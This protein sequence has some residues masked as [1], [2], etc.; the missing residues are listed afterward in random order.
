MSTQLQIVLFI[1]LAIGGVVFEGIFSLLYNKH[2][3]NKYKKHFKFARYL[4]L[5]LFPM[6]GTLVSFFIAGF[7]AI[8]IFILFSFMGPA[9][10][11][12]IGYSYQAI[13]G[14]KLWTY[15]RYSITGNTSLLAIPF[16]GLAGLLFYYIARMI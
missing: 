1:L 12:C 7:S 13:V 14:Q 9:L 15:H 10:E 8:K 16:W 5:L 11:W 2:T 6:F 4:F 3:K